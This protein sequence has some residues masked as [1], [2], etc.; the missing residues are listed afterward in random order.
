MSWL[1]IDV[2][3]PATQ[4][5]AVEELLT[6]HGAVAI[7][8]VSD[9]DEPVL[10][11]RPGET[12]LW[13]VIRLQALFELSADLSALRRALSDYGIGWDI[14]FIGEQD[15]QQYARTFAVDQVFADRLWLR[16]PAAADESPVPPAAN[17]TSLILEPGLAFGSGS[18]PTTR[19]C[20]AWLAEHIQRPVEV[21]DFG[22]GSGVLAIAAALLGAHCHAVDHD[23]QA[24]TAT[25][26]NARANGLGAEQLQTFTPEQWRAR[27]KVHKYDVVVANILAGPLISL[28]G[29]FRANMKAGASIVLSG[30]LAAQ[31]DEVM[32][33]YPNIKFN[34]PWVEDGWACLHGVLDE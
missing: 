30:V 24:V 14:Q 17:L 1:Q 19:L 20:L 13:S 25:E 3:L 32:A 33:A 8:L 22:C 5:E 11:P 34:A 29:E 21:L 23:P 6:D 15:W 31:A 28:A 10:E 7:S 12:P 4:V 18:H 27:Q 9:S 2:S 16:P 26:E